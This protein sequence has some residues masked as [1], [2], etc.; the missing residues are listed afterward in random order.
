MPPVQLPLDVVCVLHAL[1]C[2]CWL[3]YLHAFHALV[4]LQVV[5][6][7]QKKYPP[8]EYLFSEAAGLQNLEAD[9]QLL[10]SGR[11]GFVQREVQTKGKKGGAK[12]KGA[13]GKK[14]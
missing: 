11:E 2:W 5:G 7:I 3:T 12:G 1:G 13:A 10:A 8:L 14:K 6:R 9:P 4:L